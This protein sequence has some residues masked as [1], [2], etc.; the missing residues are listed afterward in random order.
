MGKT[1][2]S[3]FNFVNIQL[4][5]ALDNL[6]PLNVPPLIF[7]ILYGVF[8]YLR[9]QTDASSQYVLNQNSQNLFLHIMTDKSYKD[10]IIH[11]LTS[12]APGYG[13]SAHQS[14][15]MTQ[16]AVERYI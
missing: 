8:K 9:L 1:N 14:T 13:N 4:K 10:Y 6:I 3:C 15:F 7:E 11:L 5:F 12:C 2:Y 16:W